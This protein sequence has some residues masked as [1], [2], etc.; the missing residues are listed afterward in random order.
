MLLKEKHP[1]VSGVLRRDVARCRLVDGDFGATVGEED[2]RHYREQVARGPERGDEDTAEDVANGDDSADL[3]L[4]GVGEGL[5]QP[6]AHFSLGEQVEAEDLAI[7]AI[8]GGGVGDGTGKEQHR[9]PRK[10]GVDAL[11]PSEDEGENPHHDQDTE[12]VVEGFRRPHGHD[13][14]HRL[15]YINKLN[16]R[17]YTLLKGRIYVPCTL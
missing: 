9:D 3:D 10:S 13:F 16:E 17:T 4:Q 2:D 1:A 11:D 8:A 6:V 14:V 12:V 15:S 7:A 5:D